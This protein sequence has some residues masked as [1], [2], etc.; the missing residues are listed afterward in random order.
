MLTSGV[1]PLLPDPTPST[2]ATPTLMARLVAAADPRRTRSSFPFP[3]P[4]VLLSLLVSNN[5]DILSKLPVALN[6]T[7]TGQLLKGATDDQGKQKAAALLVGI[8]L[9]LEAEVHLTARVKGDICVGL[10]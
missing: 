9:D 7:S 1:A 3:P 5:H 8:K 2:R 10:Y 6:N 4:P